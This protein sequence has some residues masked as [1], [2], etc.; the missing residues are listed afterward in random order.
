MDLLVTG[1]SGF[2]GRNF[3]LRAPR[4]WRITA[5]YRRDATFPKFVACLQR[6][7]VAAVECDLADPA[8]VAGLVAK[9]GRDWE[10]CLYLAA[11]VDI[12]WSVREPQQD[13]LVNTAPLLNLLDA[14]HV[15]RFVY[16]SSGAVYDG[17]QGEVGPRMN[18]TPTLPYA[19][20]KLA[21]ERYVE[22]YHRRRKSLDRYMVVRFFGAYGPYE[23][24]HKIYTRLVRAFAVEG[25]TTYTI[26]GDGRNLIDAMYVDDAADAIRRIVTGSHWNAVI[27]LASGHPVTIETLV[28]EAANAFGVP[29]A[30]IQ[31]EGIAHENIEFWAS[32]REMRDWYGFDPQIPLAQGL[33]QL[34]DFLSRSRSAQ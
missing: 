30:H 6:P 29:H 26:Y 34:R 21:C 18:V 17:L 24:S 31:K 13:L 23:A 10:S 5:L 1:A 8:Q 4:D 7:N 16:F 2:L 25:Q 9:H 27:D 3:L 11:K 12:P 33:P 19:I 28:R 15:G 14:I 22:F 20:S 32:N